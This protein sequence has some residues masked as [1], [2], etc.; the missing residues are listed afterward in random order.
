MTVGIPLQDPTMDHAVRLPFL[1]PR[2]ETHFSSGFSK[3]FNVQ[4]FQI[5]FFNFDFSGSRDI[6]GHVT[7]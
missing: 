7:I 1:R 3:I 2:R 4:F 5:E 6:I